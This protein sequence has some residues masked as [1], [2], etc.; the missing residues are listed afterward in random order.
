MVGW[1]K[2]IR[3]AADH[4]VWS[5]WDLCS[6]GAGAPTRAMMLTSVDDAAQV[7]CPSCPVT[8]VGVRKKGASHNI[9]NQ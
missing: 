7:T 6:W 8:Q 1:A 3:E 4:S 9:D 2:K 5:V